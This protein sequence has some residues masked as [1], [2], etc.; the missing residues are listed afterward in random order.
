[1]SLLLNSL[2]MRPNHMTL[3]RAGLY[4]LPMGLEGEGNQM[5]VHNLNI[6]ENDTFFL[7]RKEQRG[8][9]LV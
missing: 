2:L 8:Y 5:C 7:Q 9:A 4:N 3:Q 1:M 6:Y